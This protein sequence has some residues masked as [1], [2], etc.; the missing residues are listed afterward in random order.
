M[1]KKVFVGILFVLSFLSQSVDIYAQKKYKLVLDYQYDYPFSFSAN[2]L[3][4]VR[5][6]GKYGYID[7]TGKVVIPFQYNYVNDF[8]DNGL[9]LVNYGNYCLIDQTGRVVVS[10]SQY[11]SVD[12]F[13]EGL[14]RVARDGKWG[15]I[16]QTGKQII[17]CQFSYISLSFSEGLTQVMKGGIWG[18]ADKTGKV[19]IDF[20]FED[21]RDFSKNGLALVQKDEKWGYINKSGKFVI[22]NKFDDAKSFNDAGIATVQKDGKKFCID[23]S[24]K[25]MPYD[26]AKYTDN[27]FTPVRKGNKWGFLNQKRKLIID[28]Q[29]DGVTGFSEDGLCGV[30]KDGKRGYIDQT[31]KVAINLEYE[32]VWGFYKGYANVKKGGKIGVVD[33]TGKLV[34]DC[35]YD[36]ISYFHSDGLTAVKKDEKWG[37]VDNTGKLVTNC[38]F[39]KVEYFNDGLCAV[40]KGD[41][42]G[43]IDETGSFAIDCQF[44]YA[45][46]CRNGIVNVKKN[47]KYGSYMQ[48]DPKKEIEDYVKPEFASWQ[49]K[50]KY[51]SSESYLERVSESNS[52]KKVEELMFAAVQ[53]IA[54][55]YCDWRTNKNEYDPDNQ[56]FKINIAGL[57]SFYLKVPVA[58]AEAFDTSASRLQFSDVQYAMSSDGNFFLKKAFIKNPINDKAY[59]YSSTDNAIFAATQLNIN[60]DPLK[61]NIQTVDN[62]QS[63]ITDSKIINVGQADV[64]LNIPVNPQTNDKTFAVIIANENYQKEV[65]VKFAGND[66]KIFKEYC[67]KTLGIPSQN[68]HFVADATFGNMKSEIKWITD[69]ITAYNGQAKVIFYYAGHGMPNESDKSAYLL[70][71]D[72]FSSDFETAIKL[73]DLY[74]RLTANPAQSVTFIL[75][76]CFSGSARDNG[77]L[78]EA[79]GVKV[80]PRAE[81]LRGNSYCLSAATGEETAYP[82]SAKQHGLFTYFLLK[83]L[84]ET[85]GDA[86]YKDLFEYVKTNVGQ[87]SVVVNQKSQTPQV[88]ASQNMKGWETMKLR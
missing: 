42:W 70:P 60:T 78:A 64:D 58:E 39:N 13:S 33:K 47:G 41:K 87:Q 50:G 18:Y 3:A 23:E 77:M 45:G 29:F 84:Q 6:D 85:K 56:T 55:T 28:C 51:E 14:A 15:Y 86:T 69:V 16:D 63:V 19:V 25:T 54:P 12:I 46:T 52:K 67:E 44:E 79:R 68:I 75:D 36:D 66:G 73:N 74:S 53:K 71:V 38:Q 40:M 32:Q 5:K 57:P 9:A 8:M 2:G 30:N 49:Q 22:S 72:G 83:K 43:Y 24:G 65:K 37:F 59:T 31:G 1:G 76:A 88:Q 35:L 34:V 11:S 21:A 62:T 81:V 61:F 7:K 80:K 4:S 48:V 27:E 10:L 26:E 17:D 82:F 20:Q